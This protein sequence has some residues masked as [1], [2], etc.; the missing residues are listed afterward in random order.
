MTN[1]GSQAEH[2]SATLLCISL[3]PAIDTRLIFKEFVPG[4]VNRVQEVHRTPGG[5]AAHVAMALKALG[6]E[7]TW[8]GFSGGAT[9]EELLSGLAGLGIKTI[10]VPTAQPT[11]VN[12]EIIDRSGR[13]TEILEPGGTI[14]PA[15]W[16]E[17]LRRCSEAFI[18][19]RGKKIV[20]ISG[21]WPPGLP[22]DAP[23]V[24]IKVAQNAGCLV[25]VDSSG[26]PLSK[27]IEAAPDLIKV[28]RDEAESVTKEKITDPVSAARAACKLISLGAKSAAIS[29]GE[30]GLVGVGGR[31]HSP[32]HAW[33][34]PVK[35]KST[36]GCGDA[37]LA[38]L[39]FGVAAGLSFEDNLLLAASCGAANCVATLPGR[40]TEEEVLRIKQSARIETIRE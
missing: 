35:A 19:A 39:A 31:G 36:V 32:V 3:N 14:S 20:L 18:A 7:P 5:K 22:E 12:L 9:G 15:E 40:I 23:A 1:R 4:R 27:A 13:V 26:A 21:S 24:L 30:G 29:I 28:N 16:S 8:I 2:L 6:A 33:T 10:A 34:T 17:F 38:G 37:A 11:R 25:F